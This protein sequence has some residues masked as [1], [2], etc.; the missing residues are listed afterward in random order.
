M[1]N[2]NSTTYIYE[3]D[4]TLE[5][6][7]TAVYKAWERGTSCTDIRVRGTYTNLS[8]FETVID[9][10]TDEALAT[11]VVNSIRKKLSDDVLFYIYRAALTYN[12]DKASL[13]YRYLQKAFR[14]GPLIVNYLHDETVMKIF[15]LDRQIGSEAHKYLGF[16]RF[17]ELSN[18]V[19]S[20]CINPL[21]NVVPLIADHF[22][23]R[24][25]NENWIILDTN[26]NLAA[27][28]QAGVGYTLVNGITEE[29]LRSFSAPSA[30]EEEFQALWGQFFK[31]IAIEPRSNYSLQRNM[32]PLRYRKYMTAEKL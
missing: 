32:M 11:K 26:R 22:A 14:V 30:K 8:I 20:S 24:L 18:G 17:E 5:G 23:D 19:L 3:C 6:I 13:I 12:T 16:V 7:F 29:Q 21:S 27:I 31:S 25:H 15:E 4:D 9:V 28:H 2:D 1:S 10:E